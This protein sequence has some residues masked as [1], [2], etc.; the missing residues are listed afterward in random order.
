MKVKE[1]FP[2]VLDD[3]ILGVSNDNESLLG[4]PPYLQDQGT[5]SNTF[6]NESCIFYE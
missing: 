3:H 4:A 1:T 6:H 5:D 2:H